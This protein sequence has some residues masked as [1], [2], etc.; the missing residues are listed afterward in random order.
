ME[1]P[2]FGHEILFSYRFVK[3]F[4]SW[5]IA[6]IMYQ[7]HL[8]FVVDDSSIELVRFYMYKFLGQ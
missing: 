1:N 5:F 6:V 8:L 2:V 7:L 3:V 4:H